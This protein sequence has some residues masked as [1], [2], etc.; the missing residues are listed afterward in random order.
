MAG[1]LNLLKI[2]NL[3]KHINGQPEI[4]HFR[5]RHYMYS[6]FGT[7]VVEFKIIQNFN[8]SIKFKIYPKG[9]LLID[10]VLV[11]TTRTP[12]MRS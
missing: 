11:I 5:K 4:T 8:S 1:L 2:N 6:H 10:T 3:N 12:I 7:D 9:D